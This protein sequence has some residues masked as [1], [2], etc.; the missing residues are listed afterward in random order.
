MVDPQITFF[1]P[2][3]LGNM[4]RGLEHHRFYFDAGTARLPYTCILY[5]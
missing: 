1:E 3:T 2:E 4:M 5:Y